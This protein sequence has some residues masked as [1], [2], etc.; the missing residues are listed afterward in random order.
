MPTT[1]YF[2]SWI[3]FSIQ[4]LAT[5]I[6]NFL[7]FSAPPSPT[8]AKRKTLTLLLHLLKII[9]R[10]SWFRRTI[11]KTRN[12]TPMTSFTPCISNNVLQNTTRIRWLETC[13]CRLDFPIWAVSLQS[14][15]GCGDEEGCFE[16][17]G[18]RV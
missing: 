15:R 17:L 13:P 3:H 2:I 18:A 11:I 8:T 6:S 5:T 14:S 1:S 4:K 10:V 16:L 9:L 12:M 7:Q